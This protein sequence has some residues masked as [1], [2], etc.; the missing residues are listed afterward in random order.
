MVSLIMLQLLNKVYEV[1]SNSKL[2]ITKIRYSGTLSAPIYSQML[3]LRLLHFR[4]CSVVDSFRSFGQIVMSPGK[5][6]QY[7]T[8]RNFPSDP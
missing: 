2:L 6:A 4:G 3:H 7:S 1:G 5:H 8:A